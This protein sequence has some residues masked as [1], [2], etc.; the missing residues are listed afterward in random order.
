[1]ANARKMQFWVSLAIA[2]AASTGC[3]QLPAEGAMASG[4]VACPD[5]GA[6]DLVVSIVGGRIAVGP[7]GGDVTVRS[8]Q[9]I[10]WFAAT[11]FRIKPEI[12]PGSVGAGADPGRMPGWSGHATARCYRVGTGPY[13]LK[14]WV[15]VTGKQDL[16]P[17]IIIQR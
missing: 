17:R 3:V 1:M 7:N 12:K 9:V 4:F 11:R 5:E 15:G 6:A 16:D 14:Y 2:A 8:G 13:E 10:R